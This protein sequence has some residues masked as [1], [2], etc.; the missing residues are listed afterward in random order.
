MAAL[1]PVGWSEAKVPQTEARE[2][3]GAVK[4]SRG[5]ARGLAEGTIIL[6]GPQIQ[7]LTHLP[8]LPMDLL[9]MFRRRRG[10]NT[11]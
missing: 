10:S 1:M 8:T 4:K 3:S 2:T 5:R 9:G 11:I 6:Q 7:S